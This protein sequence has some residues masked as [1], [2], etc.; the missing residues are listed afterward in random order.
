MSTKSEKTPIKYSFA[1]LYAFV[2]SVVYMFLDYAFY[3]NKYYVGLWDDLVMLL[4]IALAVV[5]GIKKTR[6]KD[7]DGYI[8][9][10]QSLLSGAVVAMAFG[11]FLAI[12][13]YFFLTILAP[14]LL[15]IKLDAERIYMLKQGHKES[16]VDNAIEKAREMTSPFYE[17]ITRF[18]GSIFQ[19]VLVSLIASVF[20]VRKK[21]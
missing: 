19:G 2:S 15:E 10:T 11:L 14:D 8:T 9:Y 4:I 21:H 17:A 3:V 5:F 18:S 20:F 6:E 16:V 13:T 12:Y 7:F 1:I